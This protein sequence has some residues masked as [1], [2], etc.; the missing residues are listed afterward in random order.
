MMELVQSVTICV[1]PVTT[2]LPVP[3]V[4][5]MS[6]EPLSQIVSVKMDIMMPVLLFVKNAHITVLLVLLV[7]TIPHVVI[8]VLL[9]SFTTCPPENVSAQMVNMIM[10]L[11]VKTVVLNVLPVKPLLATVLLVMP[12]ESK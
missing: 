1:M 7:E 5:L 8:P 2:V 11:N 3:L 10:V 9:D 12:K 6:T 4:K